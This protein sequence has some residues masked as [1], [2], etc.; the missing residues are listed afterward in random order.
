MRKQN[1][2]RLDEFF[3]PAIYQKGQ[4]ITTAELLEIG[5][6]IANDGERLNSDDFYEILVFLLTF[7]GAVIS[8]GLKEGKEAEGIQAFMEMILIGMQGLLDKEQG[9]HLDF[10][11]AIRAR[12]DKE[13]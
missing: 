4:R 2:L 13:R 5:R 6:S 9:L 3:K 7:V 10:S 8:A 12:K 1:N 11:M